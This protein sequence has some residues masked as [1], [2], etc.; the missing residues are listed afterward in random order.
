[1]LVSPALHTSGSGQEAQVDG[2]GGDEQGSCFRLHRQRAVTKLDLI[3]LHELQEDTKTESPR[4][5]RSCMFG[6][7]DPHQGR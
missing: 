7:T 4:W 3:A 2:L 5:Y 6:E 1:M